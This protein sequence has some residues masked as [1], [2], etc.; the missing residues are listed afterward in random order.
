MSKLRATPY[1]VMST[2]VVVSNGS[3][4]DRLTSL[5]DMVPELRDTPMIT[6]KPRMKANLIKM[7]QIGWKINAQFSAMT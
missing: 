3:G 2:V 5:S 4:M 7:F 1:N 6:M